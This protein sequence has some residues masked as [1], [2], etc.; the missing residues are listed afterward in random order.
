[1]RI[2]EA[3]EPAGKTHA[4]GDVDRVPGTA[5]GASRDGEIADKFALHAPARGPRQ[6]I[7]EPYLVVAGD[8]MRGVD[9]EIMHI[10][11]IGPGVFII[12]KVGR[13]RR[14]AEDDLARRARVDGYREAAKRGVRYARHF[15]LG[16]HAAP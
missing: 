5:L 14:F 6:L 10:F 12:A 2:G 16:E 15:W 3:S 11:V 13:H 4:R 8:A 7:V 9:D 1:M